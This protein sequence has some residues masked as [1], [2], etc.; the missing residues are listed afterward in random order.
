MSDALALARDWFAASKRIV[1]ANP[2]PDDAEHF[3]DWLDHIIGQTKAVNEL[4]ALTEAVAIEC[5]KRGI[6]DEPLLYLATQKFR[7]ED[8]CD[9]LS[10]AAID[11]A[12]VVVKRMELAAKAGAKAPESTNGKRLALSAS[13]VFSGN[14]P[15]NPDIK[16]LIEKL[17]DPKNCGRTS[18]DIAREFKRGDDS[19]AQSLITRIDRL[20]RDGRVSFSRPIRT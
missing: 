4:V 2:A 20:K 9:R 14:P 1:H 16:D 11:A 7:D 10:S 15:R 12:A 17:V 18:I 8:C 19:K 6:A 5:G 3:G 13:I